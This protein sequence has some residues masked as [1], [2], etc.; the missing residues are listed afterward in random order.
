MYERVYKTFFKP[1]AEQT[2]RETT[3]ICPYG[4]AQICAHLSEP[5]HRLTQAHKETGIPP[6]GRSWGGQ[7]HPGLSAAM[8]M[9]RRLHRAEEAATAMHTGHT[10]GHRG[11]GELRALGREHWGCSGAPS[12]TT[13]AGAGGEGHGGGDSLGLDAKSPPHRPLAG[14]PRRQ[15]TMFL[16]LLSFPSPPSA[17][18]TVFGERGLP[19]PVISPCSSLSPCPLS[20]GPSLFFL[21]WG[22]LGGG[23]A[24]CCREGVEEGAGEEEWEWARRILSLPS[25]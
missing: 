14:G 22:A 3:V 24:C 17:L 25:P 18:C 16:S 20:S 11:G 4:R 23:G 8:S 15:T 9:H 2:Q 13:D 12:H 7:G 6:I 21:P 1:K 5:S 19:Y 10:H